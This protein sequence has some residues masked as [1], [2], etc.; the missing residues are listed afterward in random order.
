MDIGVQ[1]F[2]KKQK[3]TYN[4]T[5]T[6]TCNILL[7]AVYFLFLFLMLRLLIDHVGV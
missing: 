1:D 4:S 7:A 6:D 3:T 5:L 2:K